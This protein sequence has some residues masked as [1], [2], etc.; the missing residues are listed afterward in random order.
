MAIPAPE[1]GLVVRYGFVWGREADAG[2]DS[3]SK[4]RPCAIVV[5]TSMHEDQL[6]VTVCPITHRPPENDVGALVLPLAVKK[7]LGLD[8]EQSWII[9]HELNAFVW[10]GV[11]LEAIPGPRS[12]SR[13]FAYGLLPERLY[14]QIRDQ[15]IAHQRAGRLR[16]VKRTE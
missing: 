3:A 5:A 6:V 13:S 1:P 16:V 10:P 2:R 15:V 12:A 8:N 7:R 9:T 14:L 11:D 4:S